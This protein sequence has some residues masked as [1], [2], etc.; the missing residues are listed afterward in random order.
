MHFLF[1]TNAAVFRPG[2]LFLAVISVYCRR[3][4]HYI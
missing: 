1:S 2:A 3:M 4:S